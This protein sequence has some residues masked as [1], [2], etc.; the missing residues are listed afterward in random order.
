MNKLF[1]LLV[2]SYT[3]V[4]SVW[5]SKFGLWSVIIAFPSHCIN[6]YTVKPV[7]SSHSKRRPKFGFQDRVSLH[8]GQTPKDHSALL[9]VF[10]KLPFVFKTFGFFYLSDRLRQV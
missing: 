5:V 2:F 10:I 7:L 4:S 6:T 1:A 3:C 9:S 8:A